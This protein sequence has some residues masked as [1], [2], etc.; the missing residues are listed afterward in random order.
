MAGILEVALYFL[1]TGIAAL[2]FTYLQTAFWTLT[3][4]RQSNK[5]RNEYVAAI[6]RQEIGWFDQTPSGELTSRI[7]RYELNFDYFN[8]EIAIRLFFKKL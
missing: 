4:T 6:L 2:V 1:Y 3:S 7:A 8:F 5:L